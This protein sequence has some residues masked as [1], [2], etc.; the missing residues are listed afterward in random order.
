MIYFFIY[1]F[2]ISFQISGA[3]LLLFYVISTKRDNIIR[4]FSGKGIITQENEKIINYNSEAYKQEFRNAYLSKLSFFYIAT[5]YL[6]GVWGKVEDECRIHVF[7]CIIFLTITIILLSYFVI[8]LITKKSKKV[9][10][11]IELEDLKRLGI[12]S[13]IGA[14]TSDAI[15]NLFFDKH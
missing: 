12:E 9:N 13:D 3:L 6:L 2:A 11:P 14:I 7:F 1:S 10:K 5:G 4:R 8:S 15:D